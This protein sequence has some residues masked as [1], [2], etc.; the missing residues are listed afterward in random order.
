MM[1]KASLSALVGE[2]LMELTLVRAKIKLKAKRNRSKHASA[3]QNTTKLF[4]SILPH[5]LSMTTDLHEMLPVTHEH[6][7]K[8]EPQ[9]NTLG[10]ELGLPAGRDRRRERVVQKEQFNFSEF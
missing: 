4:S 6:R 1:K 2:R 9:T 3:N 5:S 8:A 7:E 10:S